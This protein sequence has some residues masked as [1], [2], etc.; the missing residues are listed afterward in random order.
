MRLKG[1]VAIVTGG[2]SGIG[3]GIVRRFASEGAGVAVADF[4]LANAEKVA[5]AARRS[6][7]NAIAIEADVTK[8]KAVAAMA[9]RTHKHFG[10]LDILVNNAGSRCVKPFLDHSED[11]WNVM[12]AVNLTGPFLCAKAV[13]PYMIKGGGGKIVNLASIAS[14]VGRPER[15]AYCAAKS[16]LLGLTRSLAIDLKDYGIQVN[17]LAPGLIE[18]PFN[19]HYADDPV[20]G[21]H[22]GQ[23][24]LAGRWGQPEDVANA[25]LFLVSNEADFVNGVALPVDGGWLAVKTR[26]GELKPV[27]RKE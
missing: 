26:T 16:G 4:N 23:E 5:D 2:G 7:G 24:T 10:R 9:E 17:A 25:A 19:R 21:S 6:G 22:W 13:V 15:A 8:A 12:I 1:K 14:F 11:D 3:E 18:T 27:R 20:H